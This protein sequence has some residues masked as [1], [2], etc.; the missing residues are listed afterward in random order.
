MDVC[1]WNEADKMA[2]AEH[3]DEQREKKRKKQ[4]IVKGGF[5]R[6]FVSTSRAAQELGSCG[7]HTEH[8][9]LRKPEGTPQNALQNPT[10]RPKCEKKYKSTQFGGRSF[11][12]YLGFWSV[13]WGVLSGFE[14]FHTQLKKDE[15]VGESLKTVTSLKFGR[16]DSLNSIFPK[17]Y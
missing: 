1:C 3:A 16:L 7:P 8:K 6:G 9:T 13:F 5:V 14:G 12:L 4:K 15:S 2:N 17:R 11:C 10:Y